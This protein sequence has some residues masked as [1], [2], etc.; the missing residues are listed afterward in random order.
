[1]RKRRWHRWAR[2]AFSL[3][4]IVGVLP[5]SGIWTSTA[6]AVP[7]GGYAPGDVLIQAEELKALLEEKTPLVKVIDVRHKAKYYLGHVPGAIQVWRPEIDDKGQPGLIPAA[8]QL[9]KLFS[10]LGISNRDLLVLYSDRNDHTRLWWILA[11]LGFPLSQIR[12]LD[13]GLEAWKA[14]GYPTQLTSP[15]LK[16]TTFKL[17][18][19]SRREYLVATLEEVKAAMKEPGKVILDDRSRKQYLGQ[20]GGEGAARPGHIPGA[21]WVDWS[22]TRI[23]EGPYKGFFKS[24]AEI[25]QIY[26]ARGVTPDK[27]IYL[28]STRSR[29][30]TY[31]LVSLYLAGYPLEKL[32]IY[33]GS[34][35]EWSRS[36]EPIEKGPGVGQRE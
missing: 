11:Y 19:N 32:H 27:D 7:Q 17:P 8:A 29:R 16:R 35:P 13:G 2:R 33:A 23:P 5:A 10:R 3:A 20:E 4:L 34:W 22:E 31:T 9:E 36:Q 25:K 30:T 6:R 28:Y 24:G 12:L 18:A 1:M 21:I 14:G 26:E 15:H